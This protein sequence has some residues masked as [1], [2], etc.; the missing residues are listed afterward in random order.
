MWSNVL[1]FHS[2]YSI[3]S[4]R[5]SSRY[6]ED[7]VSQLRSLYA[8]LL[9]AIQ[10]HPSLSPLPKGSFCGNPTTNSNSNG[11]IRKGYDDVTVRNFRAGKCSPTRSTWTEHSMTDNDQ[12]KNRND[13][14]NTN[15]DDNE[16]G[17]CEISFEVFHPISSDK[18]NDDIAASIRNV[19]RHL[20]AATTANPTT[21][22]TLDI[23][24]THDNCN[25]DFQIKETE[26]ASL[27]IQARQ[28]ES[29]VVEL[30]RSIGEL[31][32]YGE[33]RSNYMSLEKNIRSNNKKKKYSKKQQCPS[34]HNGLVFEYFC[35]KN[36]LALL[37][38]IVTAKPPSPP[39]SSSTT[40][41]PAM[42]GGRV[43]EGEEYNPVVWTALVKAQVL[44]TIS[45]FIS[46]VSDTTS[47]YYL[48][49]NNYMNRIVSSI[50]PLDQWSTSAQDEI[51][52]VYIC[53]LK[54]LALKLA[55][56]P[57]LFQFFS[58]RVV[59]TG[60]GDVGDNDGGVGGDDNWKV[61]SNF[62]LFGAAVVV[63]SS[64]VKVVKEDTFI[65]TTAL[66]IILHLCQMPGEEIRSMIGRG[67]LEEQRMLVC[68]LCEEIV[69]RH[70]NLVDLLMLSSRMGRPY[71]D[72]TQLHRIMMEEVARL[73]DMLHFVNDLLWC[74]QRIVNAR[75]CEYF[76][77]YVMV[78]NVLK[79]WK[80]IQEYYDKK[81]KSEMVGCDSENAGTEKEE[82][83]DNLQHV[84]EEKVKFMGAAL[85]L[86]RVFSV[87]DYVPLLKMISVA[88]LHPYGPLLDQVTSDGKEFVLTPALN[89][90]AQNDYV[91]LS[92]ASEDDQVHVAEER[93]KDKSPESNC[94]PQQNGTAQHVHGG[95][96]VIYA[97]PNVH[98]YLM[99][100]A[101]S[102]TLGERC[103]LM[104]SLLFEI[105]LQSKAM[106][107]QMLKVLKI[108]PTVQ[109]DD[110]IS[111]EW[112]MYALD[113]PLANFF[114]NV[115]NVS[116]S[117]E[118]SYSIDCAV[119]LAIL[120]LPHLIKA[121]TEQKSESK[122]QEKLMEH[123]D[124]FTTIH[125]AKESLA[126]E[127]VR[128]KGFDGLCDFFTVLVE[129]EIQKLFSI[130]DTT[131]PQIKFKCDL[132]TLSSEARNNIIDILITK[133]MPT[134]SNETN[135][136]RFTI[137]T[138]FILYSLHQNISELH[139]NLAELLESS[140]SSLSSISSRWSQGFLNMEKT[141]VASKDICSMG[142]LD[143]QSIVGTDFV[144]QEKTHFSVSPSL[145]LTAHRG[146]KLSIPSVHSKEDTTTNQHQHPIIFDSE[147]TKRRAL[148]DKFLLKSAFS[149]T[150]MIL[151]VDETELLI[152]KS[153]VKH[154]DTK[155]GTILCT[156]LL[157]N[158]IAIAADD[159]W[160]HIAMRNV[161][162]VGVL[163]RKGNM[164]L[165]FKD[166]TTCYV[167]KKCIEESRDASNRILSWTVDMFLKREGG[168]L[169]VS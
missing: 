51:L 120:Y 37:V 30:I 6:E 29:R 153:K 134:K 122:H 36:I 93:M 74:S 65:H 48:L 110:P 70:G 132:H 146:E 22:A 15:A 104:A 118:G 72:N 34:F 52:P 155:V 64:N 39:S 84:E 168:N 49:S 149:K 4:I 16:N 128:L 165:R 42:D 125:V 147:K 33:Q 166:K 8:T 47:L 19:W 1:S 10:P 141:C 126:S 31:V 101:I 108:I 100:E 35:D 20:S 78:K 156:T 32:V 92:E 160:L 169:G 77:Q 61:F 142:C 59:D 38:D 159:A 83:G 21:T 145:A 67:C 102:V 85:T 68:H 88:L 98:R 81:K 60:H 94:G 117:Q 58:C 46:N 111:H 133:T 80:K 18:D 129:E 115:Q 163:I 86:F 167:A 5:S 45:I 137:R 158:I 63:A 154:D 109:A 138:L 66:N 106:D 57:H 27:L 112:K 2:N 62:P 69:L 143:K 26:F 107:A 144:I 50:V 90:I 71:G 13:G 95:N 11:S 116:P 3:S 113:I 121:L 82:Q 105:I 23:S 161:E 131:G 9:T 54:S 135:T 55:K 140:I 25:S 87:M 17:E 157:S 127:C 103:F 97:I 56:E 148:A 40:Y 41:H 76:M 124:I 164:A 130:M 152:L 14:S 75:F 151:V 162:D 12:E 89:A 99:M 53:F 28:I 123:L 119:S 73:D 139:A 79:N 114:R 44:Q 96:N 150:E 24:T 7:P 43:G 136:A 91:V